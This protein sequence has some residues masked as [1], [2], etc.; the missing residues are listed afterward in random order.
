MYPFWTIHITTLGRISQNRKNIAVLQQKSVQ[1]ACA[2]C[3][4]LKPQLDQITIPHLLSHTL[5]V[6]IFVRIK[7]IRVCRRR[8]RFCGGG[9]GAAARRCGKDECWLV[10]KKKINNKILN[11]LHARH[12]FVYERTSEPNKKMMMIAIVVCMC[13]KLAAVKVYGIYIEKYVC[14][15]HKSKKNR[16]LHFV[17]DLLLGSQLRIIL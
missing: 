8:T 5:V 16:W 7:Y 10:K 6:V 3:V 17:W 2:S 13:Y 1:P 9:N 15:I 4:R 12:S 14:L 11:I